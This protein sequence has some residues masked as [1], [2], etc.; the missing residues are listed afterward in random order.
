MNFI[1]IY[2]DAVRLLN[3]MSSGIKMLTNIIWTTG[4]VNQHNNSKVSVNFRWNLV[5]YKQSIIRKILE[6]NKHFK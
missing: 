5:N 1:T 6:S 3:N 2:K 4:A